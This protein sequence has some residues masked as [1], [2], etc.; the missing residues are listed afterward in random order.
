MSRQ[1]KSTAPEIVNMG[2][3]FWLDLCKNQLSRRVPSQVGH[4]NDLTRLDLSHNKLSGAIP[5][6]LVN[7]CCII[8]QF[9]RK[10]KPEGTAAACSR[11]V[12]SISNSDGR[13]AFEDIINATENFDGKYC[14]GGGGYGNVYKAPHNYKREDCLLGNILV[15]AEYKAFVP[16][17]GTASVTKPDSSNWTELAGTYGYL[18]PKHS[19]N[20]AA[21]EKC[22]LYSF[23]VVIMEVVMGKHPGDLIGH[24]SSFEEL[25]A[26]LE[27]IIGKRPATLT[28][29]A[30]LDIIQLITDCQMLCA[31]FTETQ[32][33][34]A[35]GVSSSY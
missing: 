25:D 23:G 10:R 19:Y 12:F 35:A 14:V 8:Q 13:L 29:N 6:E 16:D 20:P 31:S 34:N 9:G 11:G 32:A 26:L 21:T 28:K 24:L 30:E 5:E 2:N 17:F 15:D 7:M 1:L 18:A 33:Q 22:D 27:D 4:L 3:L